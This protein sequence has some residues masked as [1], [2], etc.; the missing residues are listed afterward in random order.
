[1]GSS[2]PPLVDN[3][4]GVD[5]TIP[6][7]F[8]RTVQERAGD[9]ALRTKAGD[10]FELLTF[11]E[12]A[13]LATRLAAG[14]GELGVGRGDRVVMLIGNRPEFHLADMAVLLLGATPISIYNSS[15]PDQI[16]Y[17]AGHARASVAIVEDAAYLE[18]VLEIRAD[19]PALR[20]VAVIDP[21]TTTGVES[22]TELLGSAPLDL[23][24]AAA[25]A[26]PHDLATVI[27]TSG[28]TG[29]P[30]GVMLDH[31]NI[32]WT[33]DSLRE[34]L[35][36]APDRSRIVSYLPMAHIAERITTHYSGIAF[37]YEVTTCADIR[38]LGALLAE[39]RPQILFG[40]PRTFEKIHSTV[41][42]VLAADAGRAE[43]FAQAL[44]VGAEVAAVRARGDEPS[45]ELAAEYARVDAESL[46][47]A[48]QL[49]G[50]D[51]LRVAV[52]A[53]APIPVEVLQFFRSAGV[54]LSELYGLSES[55]GPMT[56][57]PVRVKPGTVGRAIPGMELRLG[58]DGEV[59]GRGG[60]IFRGYLDDPERTDEALDADGWLHTGDIGQID[61]EG[62]LRIVDRKKEL[63]ITAGGKNVSPANLEA[64][65]KAQ[66]LIGQACVLGD[67]ESFIAAL[68]VL[69]PDV[70]PAWAASHGI[71]AASTAALAA[72][73]GV[74][75]EV[76]REVEVANERFS[77]AEAI[78]KF[79]VLGAEWLPDSEEL[80]PTMKLKRRGIAAKYAREIA[81][82]YS[83]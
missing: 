30:K 38:L 56:W 24:T 50:L 71:T 31:Q 60:N 62:Y 77:H 83:D 11:G 42:A 80:T 36:F 34:V 45:V 58:A 25:I 44:A 70:A 26:E 47:P 48:R 13:A 46:R 64:A 51:D 21:V 1:M 32:C 55:T 43:V 81:E 79:R 74:L 28:T 40:V 69:D 53:A 17:L 18:R 2:P 72:D 23:E 73:P 4:T 54:P 59:L 66:P 3:V 65:L 9:V 5:D 15:S 63:I 39:T 82:L 8:L 75:A 6:A 27:Y 61:D 57:D 67:G 68:V 16:R 10:D 12:Y 14:L 33:V 7:R 78:R 76:E 22:W 20:H 49:L 52:T 35:G 29:P 19:L 37:A 41:Q